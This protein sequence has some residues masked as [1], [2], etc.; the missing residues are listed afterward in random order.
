MRSDLAE[1]VD[2]YISSQPAAI[3]KRLQAVRA[4]VRRAAPEAEESISYR[5]PAYSLHGTLIYFAAFQ[6]HIGM[7]PITASLKEALAAELAPH[8]A[9]GRKNT[10]HFRHDK[11][12]PLR[13]I[14]RMVK[15]RRVENLARATKGPRSRRTG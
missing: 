13:L 8:L 2:D 15:I 6:H 11:P 10:A 7:Y 4:A 12:L 3:A 1:T 5:I 14:A 9:P